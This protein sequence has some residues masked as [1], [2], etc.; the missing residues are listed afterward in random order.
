VVE[1]AGEEADASERGRQM[2]LGERLISISLFLS[3]SLSTH[4]TGMSNLDTVGKD[5]WV[6]VRGRQSICWL[7][8]SPRVR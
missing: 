5:R 8:L 6:R 1:Y 3:L 7:K 2:I 4:T